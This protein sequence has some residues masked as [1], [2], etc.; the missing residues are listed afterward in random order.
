MKTEAGRPKEKVQKKQYKAKMRQ[1]ERERLKD[2]ERKEAKNWKRKTERERPKEGR[3]N[4]G[5]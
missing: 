5:D 1:T 4:S 2:K 3:L